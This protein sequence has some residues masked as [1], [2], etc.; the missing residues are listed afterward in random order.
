M[1]VLAIGGTG[2]IGRHVCREL[3]DRGHDVTAMSRSPT[4][5]GLPEGVALASGD[6]TDYDSIEA[7][8]EGQDA[9][10]NMVALTMLVDHSDVS[11]DLIYHQG[12]KNAI[13]AAETHG[14]DRFVQL[15]SVDADPEAEMDYLRAKGKADRAL[16]E[17]DLDYV[18][19]RPSLVFGEGGPVTEQV[20][21]FTV[22]GVAVMPGGGRTLV[23]PMWVGDL[24]RIVADAVAEDAHVGKTYQ[25]GGPEVLS[26]ERLAKLVYESRGETLR[27]IPVPMAP[28]RAGLH[29]ADLVPFVP[30]G[31]DQARVLEWDNVTDEN[32]VRAFGID[33]D[34]L[35]SFEEY[36]GVA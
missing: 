35:E 30:V 22:G 36:L 24:A 7:A 9:V 27:T 23:E 19:L 2:F 13:E 28:V 32:E 20:D 8:F 15:S 21:Q 1:N 5:E 25:L 4:S 18:I 29:A 16:R 11:H 31:A 17:S 6:V 12:T 3:D 10:V 26:T 33:P 14:V 34:D